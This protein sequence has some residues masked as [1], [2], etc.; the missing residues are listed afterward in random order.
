MFSSVCIA[1][2]ELYGMWNKLKQL[3][4]GIS[5]KCVGMKQIRGEENNLIQCIPFWNN[6]IIILVS[7]MITDDKDFFQ[8]VSVFHDWN[9]AKFKNLL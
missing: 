2:G 9:E 8:T 7:I 1:N 5:C 3:S 4:C 6:S